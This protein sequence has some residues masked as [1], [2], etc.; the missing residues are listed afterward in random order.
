MRAA[1]LCLALSCLPPASRAQPCGD[2]AAAFDRAL[3]AA[4]ALRDALDQA[5]RN[6]EE[7][8]RLSPEPR[9]WREGQRAWLAGLRQEAG[10]IAILQRVEERLRALDEAGEATRRGLEAVQDGARLSAECVRPPPPA[11]PV[12]GLACEVERLDRVPDATGQAPRSVYQLQRHRWQDGR[13][14]DAT[15]GL[16]RMMVVLQSTPAAP[17]ALR[18]AAWVMTEADAFSE[19]AIVGNAAG[20]WLVLRATRSGTPV[21]NADIVFHRR[22]AAAPWQRVEVQGWRADLARRLGRGV[23]PQPGGEVDYAAMAAEIAVAR[24]G[25]ASCCPTGGTVRLRLALQQDALS[26][27][28]LERRFGPAP[29]RGGR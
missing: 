23:A 29:P 8:A 9:H 26:I 7:L 10:A 1:W 18:I 21:A 2:G 12:L 11:F 15:R 6:A 22:D 27:R 20:A 17:D 5:D 3:C 16:H 13:A 4:P 25:D 19:P 28:S 24:D 14:L